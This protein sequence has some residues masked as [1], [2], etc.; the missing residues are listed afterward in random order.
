MAKDIDHK[1]GPAY[2]KMYKE[3]APKCATFGEAVKLYR[4]CQG[5]SQAYV[6][7]LADISVPHLS[8]IEHGLTPSSAV[9]QRIIDAFANKD[10]RNKGCKQLWS[11]EFIYPEKKTA[12][13]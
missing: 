8:N 13:A 7:K 5:F 11:M 3:G 12:A 1:L 9:K 4:T 2:F 6:A 10:N